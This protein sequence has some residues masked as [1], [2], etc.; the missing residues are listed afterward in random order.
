MLTGC[1]CGGRSFL[2]QDDKWGSVLTGHVAVD[3]LVRVTG[4]W[5]RRT[6]GVLRI[7][8]DDSGIAVFSH[9]AVAVATASYPAY[10]YQW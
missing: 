8:R 4:G 2:R 1:R 7:M 3:T 9:Q 5:M 10:G 6:A